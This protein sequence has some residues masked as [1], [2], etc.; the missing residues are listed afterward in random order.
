[1]A[2]LKNEHFF[3]LTGAMGSGKSTILNE[4]K[5][6][7]IISVVEPAREILAEQRK[8]GGEGVPEKDSK[9]FTY[10]MLS[11]SLFQYKEMEHSNVPVLFDRGIPDMIVYAKLFAID[12][13]FAVSAAKQYRYNKK[14]FY[15]PAWEE[16]Y[17]Q[18]KERKM[19]FEQARSFG[20]AI[21]HIYE[22]LGYKIINV[23]I[24]TPSKRAEFII[25][26]MLN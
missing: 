14:I 11:R 7:E 19:T 24:D 12:S 5:N 23:P 8:I 15:L 21:N 2:I 16:I 26:I 20:E 6:K 25:N 18:D 1:M 13:K 10:L 22:N 4:L 3:I 9:L 17:E